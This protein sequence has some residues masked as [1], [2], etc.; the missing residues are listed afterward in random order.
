MPMWHVRSPR[1]TATRRAVHQ[2]AAE[3]SQYCVRLLRRADYP[4]HTGGGLLAVRS[5]PPNWRGNCRAQHLAFGEAEHAFAN[6]VELNLGRPT[7]DGG[8]TG[9]QKAELPGAVL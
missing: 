5:T 1:P 4:R 9:A 2:P 3:C 6:D 8:R 7:S